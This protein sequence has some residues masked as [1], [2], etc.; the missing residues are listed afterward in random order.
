MPGDRLEL[1]RTASLL[2][3]F[4]F[5][6]I[7]RLAGGQHDQNLPQVVSIIEPW[8]PACL[9]TA[10]KAVERVHNDVFLVG[11]PPRCAAKLLHGQTHQALV[12]AAP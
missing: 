5:P 7:D 8:E 4:A 6:L 11:H 1:Q 10:A 9:Y 12:I 2:T 3:S